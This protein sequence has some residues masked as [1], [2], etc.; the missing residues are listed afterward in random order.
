MKVL[1]MEAHLS[2]YLALKYG[3]MSTAAYRN[4]RKKS[5]RI[6][7]R[8]VSFM[9]GFKSICLPDYRFSEGPPR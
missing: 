5:S 9:R 1:S 8:R 3:R 4:T 6:S 7:F 2:V